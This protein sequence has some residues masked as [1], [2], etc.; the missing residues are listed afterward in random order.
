MPYMTNA[1]TSDQ[2]DKM[3]RTAFMVEFLDTFK[4]SPEIDNN[5]PVVDSLKQT[6]TRVEK[7][8]KKRS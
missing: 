3:N 2:L 8:L 4:I 6:L 5:G 7:Q 1:W